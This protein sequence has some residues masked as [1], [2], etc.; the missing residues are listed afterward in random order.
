[1]YH[2]LNLRKFKNFF[3]QNFLKSLKKTIVEEI[4]WY[5]ERGK[6]KNGNTVAKKRLRCIQG[7]P[8]G[9]KGQ[10]NPVVKLHPVMASTIE[11]LNKRFNKNNNVVMINAYLPASKEVLDMAEGIRKYGQKKHKDQEKYLGSKGNKLLF[12]FLFFILFFLLCLF[13]FI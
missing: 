13:Y 10:I 5:E 4:L 11:L 1:M 7:Q 9:Y 12:Y 2:G 3:S 6:G 8:Y